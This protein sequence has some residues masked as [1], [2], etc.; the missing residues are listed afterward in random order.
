MILSTI[1]AD[2]SMHKTIL[3]NLSVFGMII[4]SEKS[5]GY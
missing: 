5:N 3:K 1:Q 4:G 2:M